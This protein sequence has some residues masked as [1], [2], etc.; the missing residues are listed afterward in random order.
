MRGTVEATPS[1][2]T[3]ASAYGHHRQSP[4]FVGFRRFPSDVV[5]F[6]RIPP[7]VAS[8]RQR[9][10]TWCITRRPLAHR[11]PRERRAACP[12]RTA[13]TAEGTDVAADVSAA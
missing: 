8:F 6:R 1:A 5:G 4:D 7:D 13:D 11:A 10:T 12:I 9:S 2:G 3:A